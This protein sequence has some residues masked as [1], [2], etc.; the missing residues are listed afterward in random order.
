M[1]KFLK[2]TLILSFAMLYTKVVE[3][4]VSILL[5]RSLGSEGMGY[6]MM[7]LPIAG[8][9][10]TIAALEFPTALS[11]V[12]AEEEAHS[13]KQR[14]R[15]VTVS[16]HVIL[17]LSL[18]LATIAAGIT[19]LL[20]HLH[21]VDVRLAYPLLALIP[22]V[23]VIGTT[24]ILKGYFSGLQKMKP[25]AI[26]QL[27]EKTAQ[28]SFIFYIFTGLSHLPLAFRVVAAV[29]GIGVGELVS[30][31]FFSASFLFG[32]RQGNSFSEERVEVPLVKRR[33][34]LKKLFHVSLPTTG[35][36]I[37]NALSAAVNPMII[38]Q[39]LIFAGITASVATKQYGMLTAFAMTIGYFPGFIG[40]SLYVALVPS[41]AEARAK[42]DNY[43]LHQRIQQAFSITF[44]Y[45]IP[46]SILMYFFADELTELFYHSPQAGEF[47]MLLA[48]FIL[49]HY[50]L[51][52][53][54]AILFGLGRARDVFSHTIWV[55]LLSIVLII[56]LATQTSFGIHGVIIAVNFSGVLLSFLH[57]HTIIEEI[58]FR[59]KLLDYLFFVLAG[60]LTVG[61]CQLLH[62]TH[63]DVTSPV[64]LLILAACTFFFCSYYILKLSSFYLTRL[65]YKHE[66]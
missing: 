27:L 46:C 16:F 32:E 26:A 43:A 59:P 65:F 52:P 1:G 45:G 22:I 38:T 31:L 10:I 3:F 25:I 2:G 63:Y 6:Y 44:M 60:S 19:F 23:P 36:R 57:Y 53:L 56:S 29:I 12:L 11:K 24:S 5:A 41:I 66:K 28:L 58:S 9:L 35:V 33:V 48:P 15:I 4:V 40:H 20:V 42:Q 34:I 18:L 64:L 13:H 39:S 62:V 49:F 30:L 7:V 47:L 54:Q 37:L 17:A 61:F 51:A 50:L 55:N 14:L 21:A 8:L